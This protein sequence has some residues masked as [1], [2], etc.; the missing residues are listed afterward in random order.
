MPEEFNIYCDES[1]HLEH[2]E[3]QVMVLGA[4][5][6]PKAS[7]RS[8]ADEIRA[9]KKK[10]ALNPKFE[11][12][13]TKVSPAKK[14]F[15]LSLVD[16]FMG[17]ND[18]HFR[19]LVIPD[20]TKLRHADFNQDH[21]TWHYKMCFTLLRAILTPRARHYIYF[22]IKDTK[23][24]YK[25]A[26]LREILSTSLYDLTGDI[27]QRIQP[28]RSYEMEQVQLADLLIGAVGYANR[29]LSGNEGKM[30]I[31]ERL[32]QASGYDLRKNTLLREDKVN[33][34]IWNPSG[35]EG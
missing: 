6:C 11:I 4:L 24:V 19:V 8:I 10:H 1:R 16:Y 9:L 23:S 18:L 14:D 35:P 20:K 15:Y 33:I 12:K 26:K 34:F 2:D 3:Q 13:W 30:A 7:A 27:V 31:I 32:R 5:W 22:D 21:D 28:V 17:N 29:G 25:M